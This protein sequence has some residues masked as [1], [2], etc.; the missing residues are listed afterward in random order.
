[1]GLVCIRTQGYQ[2]NSPVGA[3]YGSHLILSEPELA[4]SL[5]PSAQGNGLA[6]EAA[7]RVQRIGPLIDLALPPLFSF[8]H[9]DNKRFARRG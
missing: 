8:V 5:F 3:D 9:P 2:A 6:T 7:V 4:W 1:M